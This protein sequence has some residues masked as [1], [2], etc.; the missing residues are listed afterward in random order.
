MVRMISPFVSGIGVR[1]HGKRLEF[2]Q[3]ITRFRKTRVVRVDQ[4]AEGLYLSCKVCYPVVGEVLSVTANG[5]C[6]PESAKGRRCFLSNGR[7]HSL[8]PRW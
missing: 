6:I 2:F 8:L 7:C 1:V 4:G 3:A 5:V